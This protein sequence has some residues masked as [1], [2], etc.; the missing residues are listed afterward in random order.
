M[1]YSSFCLLCLFDKHLLYQ[2]VLTPC[3]QI[4]MLS[5][6][7]RPL[8]NVESYHEF[9]KGFMEKKNLAC[10]PWSFGHIEMLLIKLPSGPCF[11]LHLL[12][13]ISS[14]TDGTW[15]LKHK[16]GALIDASSRYFYLFF[17]FNFKIQ[18]GLTWK[19]KQLITLKSIIQE[20]GG[21]H[22]KVVVAREVHLDERLSN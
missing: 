8:L 19:T 16:A 6:L 12:C 7:M 13:A 3:S 21:R 22:L 5:F 9:Y 20:L 14:W 17:F 11:P 4:L 2:T 1:C 15:H 10:I 18:Y